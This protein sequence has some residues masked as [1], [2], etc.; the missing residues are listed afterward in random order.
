VLE[1]GTFFIL[2]STVFSRLL[3]PPQADRLLNG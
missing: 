3:H 2:Y 1:I